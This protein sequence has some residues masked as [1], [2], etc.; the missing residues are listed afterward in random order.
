MADGG[1]QNQP[2]DSHEHAEDPDGALHNAEASL[3][4]RLSK[5]SQDETTPAAFGRCKTELMGSRGAQPRMLGEVSGGS[6][7]TPQSSSHL[8][9]AQ[10]EPPT[11]TGASR[12]P[13]LHSPACVVPA[14]SD[15]S[16]FEAAVGATP[17]S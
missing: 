12:P 9:L 2:L 1:S 15:R 3:T 6:K 17:W 5:P 4:L 11:S 14:A 16:A 13:P 10:L 8:Q 7:A